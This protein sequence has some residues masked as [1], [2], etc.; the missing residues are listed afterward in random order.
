MFSFGD[1]DVDFFLP[2][3]LTLYI[4]MHDVA[5][6]THPYIVYRCRVNL[7]PV[8]TYSTCWVMLLMLSEL[9]KAAR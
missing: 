5:E 3:L 6:A 2:Q 8:T 4:N 7:L 1:D 9:V